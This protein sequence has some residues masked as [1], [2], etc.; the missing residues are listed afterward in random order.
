LAIGN[1]STF[2]QAMTGNL[3]ECV[4]WSGDRTAGRATW[5]S[6]AKTFWGTP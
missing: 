1:A 6:S 3:A 5:E 4:I 2:D